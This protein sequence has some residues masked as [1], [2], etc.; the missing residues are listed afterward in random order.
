MPLLVNRRAEAILADAAPSRAPLPFH[1]RLPGYAPTP[2][3]ELPALAARCGVAR[4][5]LKDEGA[6]LGLP[7]FKILGA[8][9]AAANTLAQ[10]LGA[11]ELAGD[12]AALRT[13]LGGSPPLVAATDGNH[14]RA[15]ARIAALLELPARIFL[16]AG[17]APAR[18]AAIAGEGAAVEEVDGGYDDCVARADAVAREIGGLL[19]QDTS[20]P[21]H[22]RLS[23][24]VVEGYATLFWETEEQ[25]RA[26]GEWPPDL[27]LVQVGVGALAQ[28]AVVAMKRAEL[29]GA[30]RIVGVEPTEAACVAAAI[31]AGEIV[32]LPGRQHSLMAGLNCGTASAVSWPWVRRG[33]Y[34]IVIVSDERAMEAMRALAAEGIVAGET[35]AAGAA[36]LLE[37]AGDDEERERAGLSTTTRVVLLSTEGATDPPNWER[38]VGAKLPSG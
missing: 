35:G 17:A 3:R 23:E 19:L 25:L 14:G 37:L 8:S 34:G 26:A 5:W 29:R 9:W 24:L 21:G 16:P 33:L 18:I 28:A 38:I 36:G 4:V 31:A 15:V 27:L 20:L 12:F 7:A 2:L 32:T 6:R 1:R 10:R 13:R 30:I 11:P 22:E